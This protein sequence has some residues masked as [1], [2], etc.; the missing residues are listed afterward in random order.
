MAQVETQTVERVETSRDVKLIDCD[1]HA[2]PTEAMLAE[3]LGLTSRRLLERYG[4]RTPRI[5]EWYPR[6]RNAGM[7]VDAWP[8]KPG[9]IWGSDPEMLRSQLLDEYGVD[10]AML[11]V[12]TGQDGYDN[13]DFS[14]ELN[15]AVNE[16]QLQTWLEFDPRLRGTIAV[17]HEYPDLAVQEIERR[18]GDS[19]FMAVLMPSNAIEPLGARKYW[20][21]Y[22]AATAHNRPVVFHTGGYSD[23]RGAGYPSFYLEYHVANG[24]GMQAQ[25]ASMVADGMFE[26]IP[27]VRVVLTECG[28]AWAA[29]LRWSL[30]AGW[31]LMREDHPRLQR[32]PSEYV[33]DH[34]WFTTQPIEEPA[35]AQH[36]LYV[37]EH[38]NLGT[39][40][41]FATDYPH[42]D[43][44]SPAQALPRAIGPELRRAIF[45]GNAL[46]LYGLPRQRVAA[47]AE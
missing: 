18:A 26:A 31:E 33:D 11:E 9:H 32:R 29:A 47:A 34:V 24:I 38:A 46:D 39:R 13:A 8:N 19:R 20:P 36:L 2:Q 45:C 6:A 1:V 35:N 5:T 40:L 42:W 27:G 41:L 16:W 17:P 14:A 37:I 3:H 21:I 7:R 30:D 25:L 15:G 4:R 28:L 44:D 10:Y 43:F 23:H 22:E 12:L